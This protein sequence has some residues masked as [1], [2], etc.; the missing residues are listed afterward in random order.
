MYDKD[1]IKFDDLLANHYIKF[2]EENSFYENLAVVVEE[3]ENYNCEIA[4][5]YN[6]LL[7]GNYSLDCFEVES[8][9]IYYLKDI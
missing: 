2:Y 9:D 6:K 1:Q 5:M 8:R 4:E 3:Y 7:K